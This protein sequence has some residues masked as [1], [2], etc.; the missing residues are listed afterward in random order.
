MTD[1]WCSMAV[2]DQ[3]AIFAIF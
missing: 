1:E 3:D 2:M